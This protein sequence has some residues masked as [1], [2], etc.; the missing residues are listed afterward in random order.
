MKNKQQENAFDL[1]ASS[2]DETSRRVKLASDVADAIISETK[3]TKDMDVLD[4]GCGTGL[5][6]LRLQPL[7]K[8]ITGAD[9]SGKMLEV[10]HQKV[11]DQRLTNVH[12]QLV[13]M[14]GGT[15]LHGI[16][17]LIVSSMT[18]H[19]L[20]HPSEVLNQ[21]YQA[22]LPGGYLAFADLDKEDGS[23][24]E[25]GTGV[26]HLGFDRERIK[27]LLRQTGFVD[28]RDVTAATVVKDRGERGKREYTIF[29]ILGRK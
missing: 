19:H 26:H 12:T 24:H 11:E 23:F 10:L 20:K 2:W 21:C 15:P 9:S 3:P 8:S 25:D 7:V 14:D 22:L 29:L 4:V 18:F 5:V 28:V 17:S 1:R 27:G 6:T 13:D 16:F